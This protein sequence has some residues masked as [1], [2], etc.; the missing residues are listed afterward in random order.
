MKQPLEKFTR[1]LHI[2][3]AESLPTAVMRTLK[4]LQGSGFQAYL[5][6]GAVRDL[7]RGQTPEDFDIAT[8]AKPHQITGIFR[9]ARIIG[10]RF[11]IVHVYQD[12][13]L[14]ELTTFRGNDDPGSGKSRQRRGT[15]VADNSFGDC[16]VLDSTRR[17]FTINALYYEPTDGKLIDPQNGLNDLQARLLKMIGDPTTRFAEDPVRMLR[18]VRFSARFDFEL[19]AA[20]A[21][22]MHRSAA[23]ITRV[24]RRR[25]S[26]ELPKT[27]SGRHNLNNWAMLCQYGLSQHLFPT[28]QIGE[29]RQEITRTLKYIERRGRNNNAPDNSMAIFYTALLWPTMLSEIENHRSRTGTMPHPKQ[30]SG[31]ANTILNRQNNTTSIQPWLHPVI[32]QVWLQQYKQLSADDRSQATTAGPSGTAAFSRIDLER[33]RLD[34]HIEQSASRHRAQRQQQRTRRFRGRQRPRV[35]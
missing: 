16:L 29:N 33:L 15:T 11:R 35:Q 22:A 1:E 18:A 19:C 8:D 28:L 25:L 26:D 5:V 7:L 23:L 32:K 4:Q 6:G 13:H 12:Q 24:N 21:A 14:L 31:I 34:A 9:R 3:G 10:K 20:T 30:L 2:R 27:L 17:D